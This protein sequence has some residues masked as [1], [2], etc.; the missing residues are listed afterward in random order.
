MSGFQSGAFQ[1]GAFQ[2]AVVSGGGSGG[3]MPD[4]FAARPMPIPQETAA[5]MWA[6][7]EISDEEY[8]LAV[9]AGL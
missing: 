6:A 5:L 9:M 8:L 1:S 2:S 7:G 4:G 3:G